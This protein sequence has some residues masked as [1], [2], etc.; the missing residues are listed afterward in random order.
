MNYKTNIYDV[1][2]II[3]PHIN[4]ALFDAFEYFMLNR[5]YYEKSRLFLIYNQNFVY[6]KKILPKD[7]IEIFKDKY[8][9][10]ENIFQEIIFL[11]NIFETIKFK[12]NNILIL[13]NHTYFYLDGLI[14]FSNLYL[15]LDPFLPSK[16]DYKKLSLQKNI[17][18]YNE[19]LLH[20]YN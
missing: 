2:H 16:T 13:D 15:L 11:K 8:S 5:K 18:I 1:I 3:T 20:D 19:L 9:I 7:I 12:F 17:Y 4:G 10:D 14:N 6:K